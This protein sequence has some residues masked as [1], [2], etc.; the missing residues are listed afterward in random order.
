VFGQIAAEPWQ[1][2]PTIFPARQTREACESLVRLHR[3]PASAVVLAHQNPEAID[4]GVFHN[5][6]IAVGDRDVFF[7]HEAAYIDTPSVLDTLARRFEATCG[8]PLR[9]VEVK[10]EE[11]DVDAAVATYLFNSQLV[12]LPSGGTA[13]I[14]PKECEEHERARALVQRRVEDPACPIDAVYFHDVR[15][16]MHG[17][18]GP[19]CLRLRVVLDDEELAAVHPG[20]RFDAEL[21]ER[22]RRWVETRYREELHPSDLADPALLEASRVAL[23]ELTQILGLGAI[24][25]F[26]LP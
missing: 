9:P 8:A 23:D 3:L 11:L 6:V 17:G 5:D 24:Y 13:L 4:A 22:L 12:A 18:G 21:H 25:P 7:F 2:K 15:Q 1:P 26:Q 16:S 19:A 10:T 20:V 14:A